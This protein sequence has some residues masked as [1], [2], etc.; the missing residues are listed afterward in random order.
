LNNGGANIKR[1][2]IRRER[3]KERERIGVKEKQR[4]E[5]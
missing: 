4:V 2:T 3:D 1:N 5:G